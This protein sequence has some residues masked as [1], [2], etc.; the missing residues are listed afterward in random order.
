MLSSS[1]GTLPGGTPSPEGEVCQPGGG[2]N[3]EGGRQPGGIALSRDEVMRGRSAFTPTK[4]TC[5]VGKGI[6]LCSERNQNAIERR[7]GA[8]RLRQLML[9]VKKL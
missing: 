5:S 1:W 9:E 4:R 3:L 7:E 6:G 2:S 8:D